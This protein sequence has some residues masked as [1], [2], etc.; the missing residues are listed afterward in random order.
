MT[1]I[2]SRSNVSLDQV[3]IRQATHRQ[4]EAQSSTFPKCD[5]KSRG[6]GLQPLHSSPTTS[7]RGRLV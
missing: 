7:F 4:G 1:V 6:F 3:V 5:G 2:C